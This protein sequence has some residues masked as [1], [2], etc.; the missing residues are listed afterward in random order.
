MKTIS[1]KAN[2][3]LRPFSRR[4]SLAATIAAASALVLIRPSFA[5]MNLTG[6]G[7]AS[8]PSFDQPWDDGSILAPAP[9]QPVDPGL[10]S[11]YMPPAP[12]GL[13]ERP[14][15]TPINPSSSELLPPDSFARPAGGFSAP[16]R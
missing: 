12:V 5:Q 7:N 3:D 8:P 4:A 11:I 2:S 16:V 15:Y 14:G 13:L 1:F 10:G 6:S 9:E